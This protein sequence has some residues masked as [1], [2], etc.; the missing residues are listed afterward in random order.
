M[1]DINQEIKD[2]EATLVSLKAKAKAQEPTLTP[3]SFESR[4]ELAKAL[5]DGR[6]FKTP[7]S[8]VTIMYIDSWGWGSPFRLMRDGKD[9]GPMNGVWSRYSDL[10]EINAA[11]EAPWYLNIPAEG[12][13]CYVSDGDA[14][15]SACNGTATV[16]RYNPNSLEPFRVYLMAGT[17]YKYATPV[18]KGAT[19]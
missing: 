9:Q 2:L 14:T 12:V 15:P 16:I 5:V 6:T 11:S 19:V 7:Y 1:T 4:G 17:G 18:N 10:Q 13:K 3:V 8:G